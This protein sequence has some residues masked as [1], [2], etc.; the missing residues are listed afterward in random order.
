LEILA[1]SSQKSNYTENIITSAIVIFVAGY[2]ICNCCYNDD[3]EQ[4]LEERAMGSLVGAIVG[5]LYGAPLMQ[6]NLNEIDENK[7]D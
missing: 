7:I 3:D 4:I 6:K 5:N 1:G 2:L